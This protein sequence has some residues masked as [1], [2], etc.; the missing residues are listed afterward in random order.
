MVTAAEAR[1]QFQQ[2][3]TQVKA[4]RQRVAE[5]QRKL[6]KITQRELRGGAYA[7][8]KGALRRKQIEKA[9]KELEAKQELLSGYGRQLSEYEKRII[10]TEKKQAEY[11]TRF[12]SYSKERA[13]WKTASRLIEKGRTFAATGDPGVQSKIRK[14]MRGEKAAAYE[15]QRGIGVGIGTLP[16]IDI[17]KFDVS[18]LP[19]ISPERLASLGIDISKPIDVSKIPT[20]SPERLAELGIDI[21][22]FDV[23]KTPYIKIGEQVITP[24]Y[25]KEQLPAISPEKEIFK[26]IKEIGKTAKERAIDVALGVAEVAGLAGGIPIAV[27]EPTLIPTLGPTPMR[28]S[29][30]GVE[31]RRIREGITKV[32]EISAAGWEDIIGKE[33]LVR[34][35]PETKVPRYEGETGIWTPEGYVP[36][37]EIIVPERE[38]ITE[39]G[40]I[41]KAARIGPEVL[42]YTSAPIPTLTAD[43]LVAGERKK[44]LEEDIKAET[45][46]QYQ[47]HLKEEIPE[48]YRHLTKEEFGIEVLPEIETKKREQLALETGV[49][50]A[51]LGGLGAFKG[52][53][54]L[55]KQIVTTKVPPPVQW[56]KEKAFVTPKGGR[57]T[58]FDI[59]RYRAPKEVK[60]TTPFR[61]FVGMKPKVDWTPISKP[62]VEV[63]RP[64]AGTYVL[65]RAPYVAEL[66][67]VSKVPFGITT[68]AEIEAL[69]RISPRGRLKLFEVRG[70][71]EI[72]T[73]EEIMKLPKPEKYVWTGKPGVL[74]TK[75]GE[76]LSQALIR[77]YQYFGKPGITTQAFYTGARV[78]PKIRIG[79]IKIYETRMG[80][81]DVT[82]PYYRAA[83]KIPEIRGTLIEIPLKEP[84]PLWTFDIRKMTFKPS[85]RMPPPT[86]QAPLIRPLHYLQQVPKTLPKTK[87]VIPVV[88]F[89]KAPTA[90][91]VEVIPMPGEGLPSMV[92]G[93]GLK[94][95]PYAG[96]GLYERTEVVS[97]PAIKEEAILKPALV[98]VQIPRIISKV[99]VIPK[100]IP[101]E[102]VEVIPKIKVIPRE[103]LK[104]KIMPKVKVKIVTKVAVKPKVIPRPI[105]RPRP[106]RPPRIPKIPKPI[107]DLE[108]EIKER[109]RLLKKRKLELVIPF[110]RRFGKYRPISK[111]VTLKKAER[112]GK[113]R[114]LTTLGAA[115]QIR[116]ITGE[117]LKIAKET[118]IFRLGKKGKDPF[119]L[120]QRREARLKAPTEVQEIIAARRIK[121]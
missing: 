103:A 107:L 16:G 7:G 14:L 59:Y 48:G 21:S 99:E 118:R 67:K 17:S 95:I 90:P 6:P 31:A 42:A 63:F 77:T 29:T 55:T 41:P 83:G 102:K 27:P 47:A 57:I 86:L 109:R 87:P 61:E 39:L 111:P 56:V 116:K 82:K 13:E 44:T 75:E 11:E 26:L 24:E 30:I 45:E 70:K 74:V 58:T 84:P 114:L 38:E 68:R 98:G 91:P 88:K 15:A 65:G 18:K 119:T 92:G 94:E 4:A 22:K 80:F 79:D 12:A 46:K 2:Q 5:A 115:L 34:T 89:P 71:A 121:F 69:A 110:V 78:R 28:L 37:R 62:Q 49:S 101:K 33:Q 54:A 32:G 20:M 105:P 25:I 23:S 113:A 51:F 96:L 40:L 100:V 43:I 64:F 106:P 104:L 9:G 50:L 108:K 120:V 81:K 52:Y 19:V 112:I 8:V 3:T 1:Q 85:P 73:P 53:R 35:I 97:I 72:I 76:E 36:P 117:P 60:I 66:G 93:L 10:S